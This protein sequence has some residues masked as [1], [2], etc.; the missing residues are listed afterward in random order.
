LKKTLLISAISVIVLSA[1]AQK[2]LPEAPHI[3]VLDT[4]YTQYCNMIWYVRDLDTMVQ[5]TF[6]PISICATSSN[7]SQ[8]K[9]YDKMQRK[10][11]KVYPYAKA[12]GDIMKM[13]EGLCAQI[14]DPHEQKRLLEQ[15]EEE[16]KAQFEKDLR[17]MTVSEGVILIKL[18]D[19]ETGNSSFKLL[20]QI[21]GRFSAF[22]WQGVAR[23]FSHNLKDEYEPE[24]DDV[25]IEN[26][27]LMIED[28]AIPVQYRTVNP[29][30]LK[31]MAAAQ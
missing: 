15:A 19:R 10:V 20:Q 27:V 30:H 13:Y 3:T 1:N 6:I 9:A 14:S 22:M 29:F 24:G 11:I 8:K 17:N 31:Q 5:A 26:I 7:R 28:G 25:W 2:Q 23:V 21:K 4:M 16:L 18:V 12:A